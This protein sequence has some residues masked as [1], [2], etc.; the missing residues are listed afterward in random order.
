MWEGFIFVN[1]DPGNT[2][3]LRDYLGELAA[4]LDGYPFGEMT[5][6]YKYR[7]DV[8]ANW[9]LY[10]DAFAEFYH[11]PVLHRSSTPPTKHASSRATATKACTT[12]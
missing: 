5:Q 11:A 6:V 2:V 10:I 1:L 7:A 3:P 8:H 9:K 4:G 12:T